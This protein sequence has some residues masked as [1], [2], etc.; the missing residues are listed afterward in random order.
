MLAL[1]VRQPWAHAI[2]HCGKDI[3]NRTWPT[4]YRG[5]LAIHAGLR[6]DPLGYRHRL[7]VEAM[8]PS[9][10]IVYGVIIGVV[11]LIDCTHTTS[12]SQWAE[13]GVW[14]W[15][16]TNPRAIVKPIFLR[17]QQGLFTINEKVLEDQG[18]WELK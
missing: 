14:H 6:D 7:I 16:L 15:R 12:A 11:D 18:L 4:E 10:D 2:I 1:T 8:L 5:P 9:T 13:S 3:E 17:G